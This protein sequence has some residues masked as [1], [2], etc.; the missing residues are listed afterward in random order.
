M[1]QQWQFDAEETTRLYQSAQVCGSGKKP[2]E[3]HE[4]FFGE[5]LLKKSG[6]AKISNSM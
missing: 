1:N 2:L 5:L 4:K 6:E 3:H